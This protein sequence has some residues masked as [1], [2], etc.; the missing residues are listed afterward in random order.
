MQIFEILAPK[1][2]MEEFSGH[3]VKPYP[4]QK[5]DVR[6]KLFNCLENSELSWFFT[7]FLRE[8]VKL[9]IWSIFSLQKAVWLPNG[10]YVLSVVGLEYIVEKRIEVPQENPPGTHNSWGVEL[11]VYPKLWGNCLCSHEHK[12][13]DV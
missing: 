7:S 1:D 6:R 5:E 10:Q 12:E 4:Q 9:K 3:T 8:N 11:N 2:F 13:F